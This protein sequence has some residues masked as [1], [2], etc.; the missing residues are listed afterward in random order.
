M[1]SWI[2]V[3]MESDGVVTASLHGSE[4]YAHPHED[5]QGDDKP[6]PTVT[7]TIDPILPQPIVK[8]LADLLKAAEKELQSAVNMAVAK[9]IIAAENR[10]E[11]GVYDDGPDKQISVGG[12][13]TGR[14]SRS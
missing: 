10:R 4:E 3:R 8:A 11:A 13:A 1:K 9:A 12:S 14:G 2:T 5:Y 7:A 6:N